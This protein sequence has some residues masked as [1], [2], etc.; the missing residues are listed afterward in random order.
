MLTRSKRIVFSLV[1]VVLALTICFVTLEYVVARFYYSDVYYISTSAPDSITGW[2]LK[3]GV[4]PTKPPY[5]FRKHSLYINDHGL[6][7]R[8]ILVPK[9]EGTT[10]VVLLGDS[11]LFAQGI[12]TEDIFPVRLETLLNHN[13]ADGKFEVVNAGIPQFGTAQELLLM[14]S[15]AEEGVTGDLYVLMVFAN[16]ILDNLRLDYYNLR[17]IPL[18]PGFALDAA[19]SPVLVH[20]PERRVVKAPE[21]T[22]SSPEAHSRMRILLVLKLRLESYLQTQ[23]WLARAAGRM[24]VNVKCTSLP[25]IITG[26]YREEITC[27]GVPLLRALVREIRDEARK[28]GSNLI[29]SMI[30]SEIQVYAGTFGPILENAFPDSGVVDLWLDDP[31][32]PQRVV[33]EICTDLG[34]PFLDLLP[35]MRAESN[36]AL[37]IA[38][39]GHFNK[40]GHEV[41]AR[42]LADFVRDHTIH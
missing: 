11:F 18:Q 37:Y 32:R 20:R 39:D 2:R 35:V 42:S 1:T 12:P 27:E 40:K 25:A 6:R 29:V 21:D 17:E 9:P 34:I 3:P 36:K 28:K 38:R 5:S 14:Q 41:V 8:D 10:R 7:N 33:A 16:D 4:L 23:P 26:W 19:G 22:D 15:L 30:P 31:D 13:A 24:G